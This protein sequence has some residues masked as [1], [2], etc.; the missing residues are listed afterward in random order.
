MGKGRAFYLICLGFI[1]GVAFHFVC[2]TPPVWGGFL[3]VGGALMFML[4][5]PR[6]GI[7]WSETRKK[8]LVF[9]LMIAFFAIGGFRAVFW[10]QANQSTVKEYNDQSKIILRGWVSEEAGKSKNSRRLILETEKIIQD[11]REIAAGG[12]V[13][14]IVPAYN[15]LV[16]GDEVSLTGKLKAPQD[17]DGENSET[18]GFSYK[19]YLA[20]D[21]VYSLMVYPQ[22]ERVGWFNHRPIFF[23]LQKLKNNFE[24]KLAMILPEPQLAFLNG[25]LFGEK[26]GLSA[27]LK[28]ELARTG[29][30][31]LIALSGFNITIIAQ[32]LNV[33]FLGL[34]LGRN[35]SFWLTLTIIAGFVIMTGAAA[36]V[37]RAA[38]MGMA[39]LVAQKNNRLYSA[40]NGVVLAGAL[41]LWFSPGQ[42]IF[43]VGFQL[44]FAAAWGLIYL[45]PIW[46]K[47]L[48]E[49]SEFL[50]LK[51]V[52]VSTL[53]AQVAVLP[54]LLFYFG[55]LSLI[56]P[57]TNILVLIAI[58]L[59]MFFG[60][61]SGLGAFIFVW[62][63]KISGWLAWL[64]LTY[65]LGI[66]GFFARWPWA[67]INWR[68]NRF[69][70][71]VIYYLALGWFVW[72][73]RKKEHEKFIRERN[74]IL[75]KL[76]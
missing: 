12:K 68:I 2:L 28:N 51:D 36:S 21:A 7:A 25:L 13:L 4:S 18:S 75:A 27:E 29:T 19:N 10:E 62:L 53:A 74:E 34:R 69:W 24:E 3:I 73:W 43:D 22:I 71:L 76:K 58:P 66:I 23:R 61:V 5:W 46:Q 67:A 50:K 30:S 38:I 20:K 1:S 54:L 42:L 32:A 64:F 47:I 44:S 35:R 40:R 63:G 33:L 39:L 57:L 9:G 17:E 55:S 70:P 37:V 41:M 14:L 60:F 48:S 26:G 8:T 49:A 59:T 65:E 15:S 52:L 11:D 31:H 16:L 6:Y 72:R 45:A 56:A